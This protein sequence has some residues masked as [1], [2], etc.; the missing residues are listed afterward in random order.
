MIKFIGSFSSVHGTILAKI[1]C[2]THRTTFIALLTN[3]ALIFK[4]TGWTTLQTAAIQFSRG[5]GCI[6]KLIECSV[7]VALC[8]IDRK[9]IA[10]Y[11]LGWTH[12]T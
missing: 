7:I 12:V 8:A 1:E 9:K 6:G 3:A 5:K 11:T 2:I 10:F 4:E